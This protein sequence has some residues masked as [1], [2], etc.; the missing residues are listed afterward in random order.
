MVEFSLILPLAMMLILGLFTGAVAY[1]QKLS[2]THAAR[3]G[4]R[5]AATVN[6]ATKFAPGYP[7]DWDENMR[8]VIVERANGELSGT[9]VDICVALVD[10]ASAT[11][12][13]PKHTTQADGTSGCFTDSS[14]DTGKRVQVF[15]R[16]PGKINALVFVTDLTLTSRAQ[17]HYEAL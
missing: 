3:E 12:V 15:V 1:N 2:L 7:A 11:A 17:A 9:G 16:R 13:S 6:L 8:Q 14:G 10:G 4:A 5:Y